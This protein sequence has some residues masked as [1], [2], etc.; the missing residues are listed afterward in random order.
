M[1]F[2]VSKI[3]KT[4]IDFINNI[5]GKK[6]VIYNKKSPLLDLFD[7]AIN[8][9]LLMKDDYFLSSLSEC[10]KN[11][12]IVLLDI[13]IKNGI[14]AHPYGKVYKFCESCKDVFIIDTF[15][16][17]WDERQ[18][19]RPFLFLN[20]N[21]LGASLI[22]FMTDKNN[23]IENY[24]NDVKK[25]IYL[26]VSP[27]EI[28]QINYNPTKNEV[29]GYNDLKKFLIMEKKYPKNKVIT[30]L[31]KYVD[32]LNSK[33]NVFVK[34]ENNCVNI[35]SNLPNNKFK[36][37]DKLSKNE[38]KKVVFYSSGIFGADEIELSKTKNAIE[39][40]NF[41]IELINGTKNI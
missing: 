6:I 10:N 25:Y 1:N 38:F 5:Q 37:Y 13:L 7:H 36:V 14:Y 19:I 27:I 2:L 22:N 16:F 33:K 31:I 24:F 3:D 29:E 15:I 30:S 8:M 28:N 23:T 35:T 34:E 39:R 40:H 18:I 21:I 20:S 9:N 32:G 11:T 26:D 4:R 41:L 17:K 12:S